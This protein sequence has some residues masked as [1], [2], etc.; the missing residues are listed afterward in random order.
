MDTHW[1]LTERVF[2][3]GSQVLFP[4]GSWTRQLLEKKRFVEVISEGEWITSLSPFTVWFSVPPSQTL[5]KP[6]SQPPLWGWARRCCQGARG[7]QGG[8]FPDESHRQ[9]W[10]HRTEG[11]QVE[12]NVIYN[13]C[14]SIVCLRFSISLFPFE[15]FSKS[16]DAVSRAFCIFWMYFS[17]FSPYLTRM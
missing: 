1:Y 12:G 14:L 17:T 6:W 10:T 2:H 9:W 3:H 16:S 4:Y 8:A 7:S 5:G 13:R 15:V 11:T